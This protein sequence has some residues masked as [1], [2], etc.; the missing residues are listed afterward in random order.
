MEKWVDA[1]GNAVVKEKNVYKWLENIHDYHINNTMPESAVNNK[2]IAKNTM[3]LYLRMFLL[4]GISLYTS[5]AVLQ[6]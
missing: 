3:M 4:L 5:R 1:E 6:V 2:R